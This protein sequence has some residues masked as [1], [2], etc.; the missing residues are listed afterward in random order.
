[1]VNLPMADVISNSVVRAQPVGLMTLFSCQKIESAH[2]PWCWCTASP[3]L[4]LHCLLFAS[5]SL[6]LSLLFV[7]SLFLS[8]YALMIAEGM[9]LG[10]LSSAST[11]IRPL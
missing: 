3:S 1:M 2:T 5:V 10:R 4:S 9:T 8:F 6:F 7:F 11:S